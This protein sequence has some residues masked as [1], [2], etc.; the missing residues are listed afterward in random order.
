MRSKVPVPLVRTHQWLLGPTVLLPLLLTALAFA[1]R[2]Y[3]LDDQSLWFDEAWTA[4][5]VS[6]NGLFIL[7]ATAEDLHPPLYFLAL[8]LWTIVAGASEFALR[9]FSVAPSVALV[10]FAYLFGRKLQGRRAGLTAAAIVTFAPLQV[11]Y[12]QEARSYALMP[13][14]TLASSYSLLRVCAEQ[15][16]PGHGMVRSKWLIS[17]V[18]MGALSL[19]T[20]YTA[21]YIVVAQQIFLIHWWWRRRRAPGAL[22]ASPLLIVLCCSPWLLYLQAHPLWR[23]IAMVVDQDPLAFRLMWLW[24]NLLAVSSGPTAIPPLTQNPADLLQVIQAMMLAVLALG[25]V[26][27]YRGTTDSRSDGG[28]LLLWIFVIGLVLVTFLT[29]PGDPRHIMVST[30]SYYLL[31]ALGVER[32]AGGFRFGRRMLL[33]GPLVGAAVLAVPVAASL[34][35]LNNQYHLGQYRKADDF[36]TIFPAMEWLAR[37]DDAVI[38]TYGPLQLVLDYYWKGRTPDTYLVP[39]ER[40]WSDGQFR[41][42]DAEARLRELVD[43]HRRYWLIEDLGIFL[44]AGAV[45]RWLHDNTYTVLQESYSRTRVSLFSVPKRRLAARDLEVNFGGTLMFHD[46]ESESRALESGSPLHYVLHWSLLQEAQTD[47]SVSLW[48]SDSSDWT[49]ASHT[50]LLSECAHSTTVWVAGDQLE[51]HV[52]LLVPPG[53]PPGTYKVKLTVY[54]T[55]TSLPL[56][57]LGQ[58]SMPVGT[59]LLLDEVEVLRAEFNPDGELVPTHYPVHKDL[60]DSLRILGYSRAPDRVVLGDTILLDVYWQAMERPTVDFLVAVALVD[61][62]G[63]TVYRHLAEPANGRYP[64]SSW[65]K[66]EIVIDKRSVLVPV[67]TLAGQHRLVVSLIEPETQQQKAEVCLGS[68]LVVDRPRRFKPPPIDH[69]VNSTFGGKVKLLGYELTPA[70]AAPGQSLHVVLYWQ[71]VGPMDTSYTAFVHLIDDRQQIWGQMDSIPGRGTVPTTGWQ[72]GEVIIDSYDVPVSEAAPGGGYRLEVGL[73]NAT[74]GQRLAVAGRDGVVLGDS[75]VLETIVD[76]LR[77]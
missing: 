21:L 42:S 1:L 71:A 51:Q 27:A 63:S 34:L 28:W 44:D 13:V 35:F 52:G 59:Q 72:V 6:Q 75:A 4:N 31:L 48:L 60:T 26:Q 33:H 15:R 57:I 56:S 55:G 62:H 22:L 10:P 41:P 53:T 47:F 66:G 36:A 67:D 18:A 8:H 20:H 73:Y 46:P 74:S 61:M 70:A 16:R 39:S 9:F 11:Y 3:H 77:R 2:L 7:Q 43:S 68:L 38:L 17:Y 69:E 40:D 30:P 65:E 29:L 64:F 24:Q 50:S 5:V 37:P 19:Y 32:I 54:D 76:V 49:Y 58:D 23:E 25:A 14:L 45:E 12:A